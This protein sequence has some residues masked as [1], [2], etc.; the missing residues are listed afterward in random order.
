MTR[1]PDEAVE[2][3]ARWNFESEHGGGEWDHC[4]EDARTGWLSAARNQCEVVAPYLMAAA[5]DECAQSP[6]RPSGKN[7]PYRKVE[8]Q[9]DDHHEYPDEAVAAAVAAYNAKLRWIDERSID[10]RL[11][12]GIAFRAVLN[13]VAPYLMA[14]ASADLRGWYK[15][16]MD[17]EPNK[18]VTLTDYEVGREVGITEGILASSLRIASRNPR[19]PHAE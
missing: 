15:E 7:N 14:A 19:D 17:E 8:H 1:I 16:R 9:R 2:A 6:S 10:P 3:L 18:D 4:Y 5:W 13:A 11:E 12:D